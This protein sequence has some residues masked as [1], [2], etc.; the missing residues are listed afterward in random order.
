M[1]RENFYKLLKLDPSENDEAT[2]LATIEKYVNIWKD[3]QNR[4]GMGRAKWAGYLDLVPE[5]KRVMLDPRLRQAEAEK[6]KDEAANKDTNKE[7]EK[8][9]SDFVKSQLETELI[10]RG[11]L[12]IYDFLSQDSEGKDSVKYGPSNSVSD[13]K[14]RAAKL[15]EEYRQK[16]KAD[17]Q[18]L[19]GKCTA[20]LEKLENLD[21]KKKYDK[22]VEQKWKTKI[23]DN[24]EAIQDKQ[25]VQAFAVQNI[26]K[27]Y[28][29]NWFDSGRAQEIADNYC[30]QKGYQVDKS[31]QPN[32]DKISNLYKLARRARADG[33]TDQAFRQY[34]AL[35]QEDPDNWE[36]NFYA[37]FYSGINIL[38]NDEPGG[39]V[40]IVGGQV[41]LSYEYRSGLTPC[42]I[43][44]YNCLDTVF[45]LI[46]EI[47]DYDEQ[48]AAAT[49]VYEN[50]MAIAQ[51]LTRAV[52]AE[53]QRMK[54][55]I[56][57]FATETNESDSI[58][59]KN[60]DKMNMGSTNNSNRDSYKRD[61]SSMISLV[62]SRKKILEEIVAKRRFDE[63][64]G[65]HQAE[66]AEFESLKISL[67]Q[68]IKELNNEIRAIPGQADIIRL[69]GEINSLAFEKNAISI[70]KRKE[71]Q[72][73]QMEIDL[74][75]N[76]LSQ[77]RTRLAPA[78]GALQSR[79]VP[80]INKIKEIDYE[81]TRP[82]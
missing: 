65:A 10:E 14:A 64:W 56:D 9:A 41:K 43:R 12:S 82:R 75:N 1:D 63:Y 69:T 37:A 58:F 76:E 3:N 5:I 15:F 78:V 29:R 79:I 81:L 61:I 62:E 53:H 35:L 32:S 48:K 44:I 28:T 2:I 70:F 45:S 38:K 34:D 52:D 40:R 27:K 67:N 73:V 50:V 80:L 24:I 30:K 36:P 4:G 51:Q 11:L 42:I 77:I 7:Y 49:E 23:E 39:S 46:E 54:Q 55:E 21:E 6:A 16:N 22:Y 8:W 20:F 31:S 66:K 57:H 60:M 71:R 72:A 47:Q 74:R 13:L 33:N 26:I 68:Q 59:L 25:V 19:I 18:K 17:E